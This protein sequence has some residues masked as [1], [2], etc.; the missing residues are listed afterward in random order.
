[1]T[2][3]TNTTEALL[4]PKYFDRQQLS[5]GDLNLAVEYQ[6]ARL[7][8]HNRYLHGWGVVV[9]AQV[10]CASNEDI[11]KVNIAEGYAVTPQGDEI[12]IP[13]THNFD[14]LPYIQNCLGNPP[15][16]PDRPVSGRAC[17]IQANLNPPGRDPR[18]DYNSEWVELSMLETANLR[19]YTVRHTINPD[20]D[21]PQQTKQ[22]YYTIQ[23]T[24]TFQRGQ[25]IRIHSGAQAD[26]HDPPHDMQN[27]YVADPGERGNWRLNN[28]YDQIDLVDPQ[29]VVVDTRDFYAGSLI[30]IDAGQVY[31]TAYPKDVDECPAP[32]IPMMC[33]PPGMNYQFSRLRD[34]CELKVLCDLPFSHEA[35]RP[36]SQMVEKILCGRAHAP[37]PAN[38]S[39][40]DN[41]VVLATISVIEFLAVV[42]DDLLNRKVLLSEELLMQYLQGQC[43]QQPRRSVEDIDLSLGKRIPVDDLE[44]IGRARSGILARHGVTTLYDLVNL[45]AG[46]LARLLAIS[47][48]QAIGFINQAWDMMRRT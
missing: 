38:I 18:S 31:L 23:S 42:V 35:P 47:E 8:R 34:S 32:A 19:G 16:C 28:L 24:I 22:V 41:G 46:Q 21:K 12:Y 15:G 27:L 29:G 14:L 30:P 13:P 11:W 40:E 7:R 5:P 48:A 17:I 25:V 10:F 33:E 9:G 44:G 26:D 6:R 20:P 43:A 1:M 3:T 4:R 37:M 36:D 45:P 2:P 39:A